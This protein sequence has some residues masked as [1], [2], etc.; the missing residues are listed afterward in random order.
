MAIN[1]VFF[2]AIL[3]GVLTFACASKEPTGPDRLKVAD[4]AGNWTGKKHEFINK[5]DP[6]QKI[7]IIAMGWSITMEIKS[8]GRF[9]FR[10]EESAASGI[11]RIQGGNLILKWDGDKEEYT[12]AFS[13]S[14]NRLTITDHNASY[15]FD[16]DG[17]SE[18]ATA[19]L[20]LERS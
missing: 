20:V 15:D 3:L 12:V 18:P 1:R 4:L 10:V 5:M 17:T 9:T 8:N 14:R 11:L 13:L 19:V 2:V 7:D 6:A 16:S